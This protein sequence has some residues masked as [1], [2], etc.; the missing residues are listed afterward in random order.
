MTPMPDPG[1]R[2]AYALAH[3]YN[4]PPDDIDVYRQVDPQPDGNLL[5]TVLCIDR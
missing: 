2:L 4:G 5:V 1:D 3:P